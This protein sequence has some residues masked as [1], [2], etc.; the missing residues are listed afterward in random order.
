MAK[1]TVRLK[2][3]L[4]D[5]K[6]Y[7]PRG[8]EI[9]LEQAEADRLIAAGMAESLATQKTEGGGQRTGKVG[10]KNVSPLRAGK[11]DPPAEAPG[12]AGDLNP[13]NM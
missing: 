4:Y 2:A 1:I 6:T 5:G 8:T 9:S 3:V 7:T 10:A 11:D 13:D 12:D